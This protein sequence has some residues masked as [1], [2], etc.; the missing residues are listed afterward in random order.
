MRSAA[1][2]KDTR[3]NPSVR[4]II[5]LARVLP[6]GWIINFA[7]KM[8]RCFNNLARHSLNLSGLGSSTMMGQRRFGDCRRI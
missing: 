5:D 8:S 2:L 6:V 7:D 3:F 1:H 4:V